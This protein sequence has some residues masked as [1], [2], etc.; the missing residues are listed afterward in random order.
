MFETPG[1]H[2]GY[3]RKMFGRVS[4]HDFANALDIIGNAIRNETGKKP[5]L[6][7][8]FETATMRKLTEIPEWN[9]DRN[10]RHVKDTT[11][12]TRDQWNSAKNIHA[13][14]ILSGDET[15]PGVIATISR[16][17]NALK[18]IHFDIE[19]DKIGRKI[20]NHI[21]NENSH[22]MFWARGLD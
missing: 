1:L 10:L 21:L 13:T 5:T 17:E 11:L 18:E 4:R 12:L 9:V 22:Y 14:F 8:E 19:P 16:R 20:G 7:I 6:T 15:T 2:K 3:V